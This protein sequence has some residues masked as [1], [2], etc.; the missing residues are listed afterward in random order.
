LPQTREDGEIDASERAFAHRVPVIVGPTA[1]H[2]VERIDQIGGRHTQRG[3]DCLSDA[4]QEG[5]DILPG[6]LDEQFPIGIGR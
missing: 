6:R 4:I 5:F 3:F 2:R 1:D